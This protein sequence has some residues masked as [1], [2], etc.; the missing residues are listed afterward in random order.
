MRHKTGL[1]IINSQIILR[2]F[3][4]VKLCLFLYATFQAV[5]RTIYVKVHKC[6]FLLTV[7]PNFTGNP[8]GVLYLSKPLYSPICGSKDIFQTGDAQPSVY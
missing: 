6:T 1:I 4:Q 3:S 7:Y 2:W 8:I 5:R